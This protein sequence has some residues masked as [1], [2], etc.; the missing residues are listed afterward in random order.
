MTK[1]VKL[2]RHQQLRCRFRRGRGSKDGT[3]AAAAAAAAESASAAMAVAPSFPSLVDLLQNYTLPNYYVM[4][5]IP[6]SWSVSSSCWCAAWW[7]DGR[8]QRLLLLCS[9]LLSVNQKSVDVESHYF[10]SHTHRSSPQFTKLQ[11]IALI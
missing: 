6:W 5:K 1:G 3:A 8:N 4:R 11:S 7:A 2:E 10:L 9:F